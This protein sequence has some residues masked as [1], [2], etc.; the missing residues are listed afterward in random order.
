MRYTPGEDLLHKFSHLLLLVLL[1]CSL[2]SVAPGYAADA[3][4]SALGLDN[5]TPEAA[6][7][8]RSPRPAS[9]IAENVTVVTADDIA[10]LNAHTLADVLQTIPGIQLDYLRTPT[11]FTFFGI[12]GTHN[13]TVLVLVDGVRQNDFQLDMAEPGLIP[14]QQIERIEIVKG[15]ASAAWGSALGGVINIVTKSPDWERPSGGLLSGSIGRRA[16]ADS[17]LELSGAAGSIGYYL[18]GGNIRSDGLRPNN[19][20]ELNHASGKVVWRDSAG[21]VLTVGGAGYNNHHGMDEGTTGG[22]PV[23]DDASRS[24]ASG[25]LKYTRPL[26]E[27]L[28]LDLDGYALDRMGEADLNDRIAGENLPYR[29]TR[30]NE[31]SRGAG[32]RLSWG[33]SSRNLVAGAEFGHDRTKSEQ[34]APTSV[35]WFDRDW[36]RWA[37][38]ANGTLSIGRVTVLP[39]VRFDHTGIASDYTSVTLGATWQAT[40]KTLLRAYGARGYGLPSPVQKH[41][42][43]HVSTLQAGFESEELP[44]LWIKGTYFFN[45]LRDIELVGP[46]TL[47]NQ[48]RQG[49]EM[50]GRTAPWLGLS[51]TAGYTFTYARDADSGTRVKTANGQVV[52]SHLLKMG[53]LYDEADLGVRGA[54]TGS[55]VVWNA[56]EGDLS[57]SRGMV[58]DL[59]LSWKVK[60]QAELSPVLFFSGRNLFSNVQTTDAE[61]YVNTPRWFEGGVRWNF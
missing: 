11:T 20:T 18:A 49:F 1:A 60:P 53:I 35:L 32:A 21:G 14:V 26:A 45:R 48:D 37:A 40:G 17:R 58:W 24:L 54:L 6:P 9:K 30:V 51:L 19:G 46:G 8:A 44:F 12:Q 2:C 10:R 50:E 3:P 7:V 42:L 28:T 59:H 47:S 22:W 13:T 55:H 23:H 29:Y 52:P 33:D 25:S 61:L 36:N 38:Y 57:A 56:V 41:D 4:A 15:A 43:M 34:I 5:E 39:G 31:S 27:R 16:T